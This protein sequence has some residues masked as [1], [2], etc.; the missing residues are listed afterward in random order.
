MNLRMLGLKHVLMDEAGAESTTSG[1]AATSSPAPAASEPAAAPAAV[2]STSTVEP[3]GAAGT[4]PGE[5]DGE[6]WGA[7]GDSDPDG[8]GD[9]QPAASAPAPATTQPAAAPAKA[10]AAPAPAAATP[11][12]A[13]TAAAQPAAVQA[14]AAPQPA[15]AQPA[16]A[17]PAQPAA[18]QPAETPEAKAAREKAEREAA[19]AE[20]QK[21]M[22]GLEEYYKLP[23]ADAAA[24]QTEPEIALPRLAAKV[25]LAVAR[26]VQQMLAQQLP[27]MMMGY[28]QVQQREAQAKSAFYSRWSQLN[29]AQHGQAILQA[30][31]LFRQVNPTATP[32]EAI[33]RIGKIVCESLG[34]P[35]AAPAA[36]PGAAPVAPAPVVQQP[37]AF[38]PAGGATGARGAAPSSGNEWSEMADQMLVEGD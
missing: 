36:S 18:A 6:D 12:A 13:A 38:R 17:Q 25:H 34:I 24:L 10:P 22:S 35:I 5:G 3:A 15:V 1:S 9:G 27:Q 21:L 31:A 19:A 37:A 30:G 29:E 2:E 20:E 33:E 7:L 26:G 11:P 32:E 28:Q 8:L 23:E 4:G 16:A 14:P